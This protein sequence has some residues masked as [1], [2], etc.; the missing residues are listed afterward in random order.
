MTKSSGVDRTAIFTAMNFM[1]ISDYA[2]L[3]MDITY[4]IVSAKDKKYKVG[5][6]H[7]LLQ[8]VPEKHTCLNFIGLSNVCLH[9]LSLNFIR[10]CVSSVESCIACV[11]SSS[12]FTSASCYKRKTPS[13]NA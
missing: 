4:N 11:T 8:T 9:F 2:P 1:Q 6:L 12:V 10:A 3:K 5:L 13:K 7:Y